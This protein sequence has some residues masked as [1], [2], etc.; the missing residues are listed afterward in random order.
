MCGVGLGGSDFVLPTAEFRPPTF[1]PET[2]SNVLLSF[3]LFAADVVPVASFRC[4]L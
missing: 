2:H 4:R 1:L 3:F